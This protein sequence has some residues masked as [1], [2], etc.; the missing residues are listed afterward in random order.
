MT[1]RRR[2]RRGPH[3]PRDISPAKIEARFLAAKQ[4]LR[5]TRRLRIEEIWAQPINVPTRFDEDPPRRTRRP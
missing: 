4:R 5:A 3:P 1:T 2:R